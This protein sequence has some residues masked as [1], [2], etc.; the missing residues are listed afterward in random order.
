MSKKAVIVQAHVECEF[1]G[2]PPAYR[3]WLD[4]E[5]FAE[6]TWRFEPHQYLEEQWQ[7]RARPGRYQLRYELLGAGRLTVVSWSVVRG[8]AGIDQQGRL[9]I[10][11][12]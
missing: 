7:I 12:A 5:L 11:D 1:V 6:R 2:Q 10:H 4:S 8:T 9:V 3:A